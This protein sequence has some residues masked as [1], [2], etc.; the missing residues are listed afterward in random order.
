MANNSGLS[1]RAALRQQQEMEARQSRNRRVVGVVLAAVGVA[2]VAIL[3]VVVWQTIAKNN[4]AVGPQQQPVSV[5]S[6]G[7]IAWKGTGTPGADVPHLVVYEDYQCPACAYYEETY[8][9]ALDTLVNEGKITVEFV[10]ANFMETKIGNDSSTR[11]A[12]AAAA[13]DSVGKFREYQKLV[14]ANQDPNGRGYTDQQLR[15]DFPAQV[16]ITGDDLVKFQQLYDTRAFADFV[17]SANEKFN[18]SGFTSTPTYAVNGK[19]LVFA[20]EASQ[21]MLIQ[22]TPEDLLRA[23]TE[24]NG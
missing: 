22:P 1:R 5:T 3:G 8:G 16:G 19:K 24:A 11:A 14:F 18:T 21:Q 9:A 7:G 4:V 12:I 6:N 2:V 20:D 17:K 23:I 15:V 13:A 10:T